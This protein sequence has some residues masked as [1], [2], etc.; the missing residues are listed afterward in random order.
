MH[1]HAQDAVVISEGNFVRGEIK[2][3]N[4]EIVAIEKENNTIAQYNAKDVQSFIWNG[5]TY[6]SK[7]ILIDR[8][9]VIRFF[10]LIAGG[11]VNL[12]SMGDMASTEA[13]KMPK[14]E[15]RRIKPQIGIGMGSGGFG[16]LGG[17]ISFGNGGSNTQTGQLPNKNLGW[18]V[19]YYMDKPGTGAIQEI[20]LDPAKA[21]GLRKILLQKLGDNQKVVETIKTTRFFNEKNLPE[22]VATYNEAQANQL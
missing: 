16:G 21:E 13:V 18:R 22:L 9:P 4:F 11:V 3:T 5:Q 6:E 17:G 12:Y 15:K 20:S 2:G 10:K 7:P 14:A 19:S 8:K 1:S